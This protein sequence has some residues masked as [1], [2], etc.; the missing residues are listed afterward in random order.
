MRTYLL[1]NFGGP[2]NLDEIRPFLTE[3]LQDQDVVRTRFP[4]WLHRRIFARAAK[5]RAEQVREDYEAIGGKSP[6]YA[7]T[8]LLAQKL[9]E[10]LKAPVLTFHRYLPSTHAESLQA[11]ER[12]SS[13]EIRVIPC[14]P[15][16]CY[17]TTGSIARFFLNNLSAS[18]LHKL[19]WVHSY[20]T[21]P[22]Y[23]HAF[24]QRI[25]EM[26]SSDHVL[27]LFSAHGIPE[28]FVSTGDIYATEC[29]QSF[30]AIAAG[31]PLAE[32]R[33]CYQSKFGKG[34]WL[35]PYTNELCETLGSGNPVV[36]VPLSFTSDH[37][38]TLFE[39]EELYLPKIRAGGRNATRCP[40]LNLEPYWVEALAHIAESSPLTHTQML[41]RPS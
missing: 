6:I 5:R 29:E 9:S 2:R 19:R 28:A 4:G 11:I 13:S 15:Q 14:F 32:S 18:A 21:H 33:L 24:Q 12:C 26:L 8:E 23:I 27:L 10:K 37:M 20:A 30:R 31:F 1:V 25:R 22:A 41:V 16:F 36:V 34:E 39:I 17:A 7:D 35:K 38:E 40:A 3:L